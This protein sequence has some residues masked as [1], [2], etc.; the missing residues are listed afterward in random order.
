MRHKRNLHT[1]HEKEVIKNKQKKRMS[2]FCEQE[3]KVKAFRKL[4]L[5]GPTFVCVSCKRLV[6]EHMVT[7]ITEFKQRTPSTG[8]TNNPIQIF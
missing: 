7:K 1:A 3:D 2:L 8:S 5:K 6:H 4:C